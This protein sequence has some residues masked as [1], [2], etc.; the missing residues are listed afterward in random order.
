VVFNIHGVGFLTYQ[1]LT[2]L[3]LPTIMT[4]VIYGAFFIVV[5]NVLVDIGY[6]WLDPRVRPA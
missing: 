6:A 5:A 1:A 2:N 4:T 3:D